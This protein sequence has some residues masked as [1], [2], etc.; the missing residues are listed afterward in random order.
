VSSAVPGP[1]GQ[2]ASSSAVPGPLG[3]AASSTSAVPGPHGQAAS[4]SSFSSSPTFTGYRKSAADGGQAAAKL[5]SHIASQFPIFFQI[6]LQRYQDVDNPSKVLP[7]SSHGVVHH[8]RMT[9]PPFALPFWR[10]DAE[11]LAAAKADFMKMEAEGIIRWSSTPWASPL[12]L[13]KKL[14]GSWRPC[15]NFF[16]L[17]NVNVPDTYTLPNMMDFSAK[18]TGCNFFS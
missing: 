4:S 3:Q 11:K 17:N 15:S 6:L 14:D 8:L 2:A 7:A 13:V 16:R 1:L 10:L 5:G 18:V 9:G 12:N